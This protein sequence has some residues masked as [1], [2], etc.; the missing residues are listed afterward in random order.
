MYKRLK[1]L[2]FSADKLLKHG[3][4]FTMHALDSVNTCGSAMI[5]AHH[6]AS[7]PM[8]TE[9]MGTRMHGRRAVD[10]CA[11]VYLV[12]RGDRPWFC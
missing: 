10:H 8:A 3:G 6:M 12:Q 4:N 5:G 11:H 1:R 9:A 7:S 2:E